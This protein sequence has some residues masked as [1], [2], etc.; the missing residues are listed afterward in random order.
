MNLKSLSQQIKIKES[1]LCV[2]LDID[3][4]KIPSHILNEKDPIFVFSKISI[5]D[6]TFF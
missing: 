2:G 1:F 3:L 4:S 6:K 5:I